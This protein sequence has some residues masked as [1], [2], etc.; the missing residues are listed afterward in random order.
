MKP[1]AFFCLPLLFLPSVTIAGDR[2]SQ[3]PIGDE[4]RRDRQAD[5]ALDTITHTHDGSRL[6][7][8]ALAHRLKDTRLLLVGESHTSE[9]FHRVQEVVLRELHRA[10]RKVRIGLEM[11]P[12]DQQ[13]ILDRWTA[14]ELSEEQFLEVGDWYSHWGYPWEYYR[15]IFQLARRT[16][17]PMHGLN[18]PRD[19]VTKV[20]KEGFEGLDE[21]SRKRLPPEIQ[22]SD[23]AYARLFMSYF[24]EDSGMHS[25]EGEM[26][27]GFLRAQSVWDASMAWASVELL[28]A[29]PDTIL[30]VLIGSGHVA[31]GYGVQRQA[32]PWMDGR[33]ST[34]IPVPVT[35][36]GEPVPSVTASYADFVWGVAEEAWPRFPSLGIS[37]RAA[38]DGSR[39]VL[40]VDDESPSAALE[41]EAG[42]VIVSIDGVP[43]DGPAVMR[44]AMGTKQWGD[45]V[46]LQW[47]R[48]E[49][50]H[51]GTVYLRRDQAP[52]P[53]TTND[54]P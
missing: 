7:P 4:A 6:T 10:G 46:D 38:D 1:I 17:M 41:L 19:L 49:E 22:P 50:T 2:P 42:D 54:E 14:G 52:A 9:E 23:D 24:D 18:V 27:E 31:Y 39:T 53:D 37:T 28:K 51:M 33:I 30:V 29:H 40:F 45:T 21:A 36:D 25:M 35:S 5:V 32:S 34:L 12:T 47:R 11:M 13:P 15:S 16:G 8:S 3:L 26:L 44:R 43:V 20:R 48:G